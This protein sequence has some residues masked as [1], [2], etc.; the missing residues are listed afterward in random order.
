MST[1]WTI[2]R[3]DLRSPVVPEDQLRL[4]LVSMSIPNG[5]MAVEVVCETPSKVTELTLEKH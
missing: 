2:T 5:L 3:R 4:L 1:G